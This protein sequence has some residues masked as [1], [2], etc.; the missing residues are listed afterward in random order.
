V[1]PWVESL[2][3]TSDVPEDLT[4]DKLKEVLN[5]SCQ[6]I[7]NYMTE[8]PQMHPMEVIMLKMREADE[9]TQQFG[10]DELAIAA[11]INKY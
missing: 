2:Q 9:I 11:A 5:S 10:Y 4:S 7:E 8:H 3:S 1:S 6:F